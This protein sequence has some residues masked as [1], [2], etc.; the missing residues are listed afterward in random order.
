MVGFCGRMA[1]PWLTSL[2]YESLI[3][4][5]LACNHNHHFNLDDI[6]VMLESLAREDEDC[7]IIYDMGNT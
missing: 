4:F 2:N 1:W 7:R 3:D 6:E 5:E